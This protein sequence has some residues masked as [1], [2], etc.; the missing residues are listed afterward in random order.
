MRKMRGS[1]IIDN[2]KLKKKKHFFK[3][4]ADSLGC[5]SNLFNSPFNC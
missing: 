4:S 1:L 2:V 3:P 5:K